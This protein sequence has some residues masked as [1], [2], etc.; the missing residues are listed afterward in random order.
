MILKHTSTHTHT[1]THTF[2]TQYVQKSESESQ[3]G[4]GVVMRLEPID[5]SASGPG[6][7]QTKK[8]CAVQDGGVEGHVLTPSCES[9]GITTNC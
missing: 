1:H 9:T 6:K 4:K 3:R 2:Q 8:C 5:G 7:K